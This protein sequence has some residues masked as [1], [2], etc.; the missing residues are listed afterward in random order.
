MLHVGMDL[1]RHRLDVHVMNEEG[2]LAVETAVVP[3]R[4]GLAGL[5][6]RYR[7]QRV[8]AVIES[9]NGARFVHDT[10]S[11]RGSPVGSL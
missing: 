4:P 1:S 8:R 11:R 2:G 10:R 5:A 3:D 7:G 9:M 6:A